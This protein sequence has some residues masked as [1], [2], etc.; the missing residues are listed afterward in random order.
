MLNTKET[1]DRIR[2]A[3][4]EIGLTQE[5]LGKM[6]G[7]NKSTVQRYEAGKIAKIKI[8]V[9]KEIAT[10]LAVSPEW[11][12][13]ESDDKKID[14][15]KHDIDPDEFIMYMYKKLD[16]EDRIK[17]RSMMIK[18]IKSEKYGDVI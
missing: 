11:L 6:L 2:L 3:R 15:I 16:E 9:I 12:L 13:L 7:M 4:E 8:P 10:A 17:V 18:L 14:Y 1:G 5:M